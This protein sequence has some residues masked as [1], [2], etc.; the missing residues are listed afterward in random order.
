[1]VEDH[2]GRSIER[3]LWNMD[4]LRSEL[5]AHP[6]DGMRKYR[7]GFA[8]KTGVAWDKESTFNARQGIA[9]IDVPTWLAGQR[10]A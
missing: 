6:D 10:G 5:A 9:V 8:R 2:L 1:M 7:L 3:V 4:T